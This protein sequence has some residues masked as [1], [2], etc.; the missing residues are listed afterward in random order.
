[1]SVAIL[2]AAVVFAYPFVIYPALLGAVG[3]L[4]R[5]DPGPAAPGSG[6]PSVALVIC[7]LNEESVIG[8]KMENCLRLDYPREKLRV[9]VVSDG[10]TDRTAEIVKGFENRGIELVE[11]PRRRGKI[12]N[13]N[14][15]VP[16]V[17]EEIVV[18]SD[19][20]VMYDS[21]ALRKLTARFRDPAV[22]C[23]S[24]RVILQDTTQALDQGTG[25]YYSVEWF[26]QD[27]SSKL[28]S[29][30]GADGAMYAIRRELFRP[31]PDDTL[32][33]DLVIPMA[34][35][36]QGKRVVFEPAAVGWERGVASLEE[37]Y[38]RKVR[39][40]AGA[41]Q[42]M[43]R[44]NAWPQGAPLRFWFI[45]VSHKLLRWLSPVMAAVVIALCLISPR[46]PLSMAVLAGACILSAA[47]AFYWW[48][49]V[50]TR[51]LSGAFYFV[52]G[53]IALAAGLTK[54]LLGRQTVLWAKANR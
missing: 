29:M 33:E 48:A 19:A 9:I 32:I 3:R 26:L 27:E 4:R 1:M 54:G 31:C 12:A 52:F 42:G 37:E 36:R 35:V 24:G 10:S 20:N 6:C 45:F 8:E 15:I 47:A 14:E 13:L 38:R 30:V 53:Q 43:L 17:R 28:Y 5:K 25:D 34:V 44:G 11:R 40:A 46:E 21:A 23:V 18:L 50:R 41:M 7:A 49:G 51:W 2:I 39:I 22:G 16:G